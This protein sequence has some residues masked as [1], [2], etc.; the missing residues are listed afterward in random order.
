MTVKQRP[1]DLHL[2]MCNANERLSTAAHKYEG[3]SAGFYHYAVQS[4]ESA[5]KMPDANVKHM[6]DVASDV[7]VE[8][9][10][11]GK[12]EWFAVRERVLEVVSH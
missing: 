7:K 11:G 9:G 1:E 6:A 3:A 4:Y 12:D 8:V 5:K 2:R 10:T